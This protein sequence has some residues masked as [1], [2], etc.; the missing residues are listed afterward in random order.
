MTAKYIK[1]QHFGEFKSNKHS[2][3]GMLIPVQMLVGFLLDYWNCRFNNEYDDEVMVVDVAYTTES[4]TK[5]SYNYSMFRKCEQAG[6]VA[7]H[8]ESLG[9]DKHIKI[10]ITFSVTNQYVVMKDFYLL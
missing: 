1:H 9:N 2:H 3:N 4:M 10:L 6:L 8:N 5:C 7:I